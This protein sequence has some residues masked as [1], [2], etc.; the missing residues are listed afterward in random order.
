M[1]ADKVEVF[2]ELMEGEQIL[3]KG[4]EEIEDGTSIKK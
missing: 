1:M 4:S 3:V 2:G